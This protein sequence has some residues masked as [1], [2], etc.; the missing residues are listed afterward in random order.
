MVSDTRQKKWTKLNMDLKNPI[1]QDYFSKDYIKHKKLLDKY[2]EGAETFFYYWLKYGG[3]ENTIIT[4]MKTLK[5]SHKNFIEDVL[6]CQLGIE[7]RHATRNLE[8]F[9]I[10]KSE[11]N[12]M[13]ELGRAASAIALQGFDT[14]DKVKNKMVNEG[15]NYKQVS[16]A[17]QEVRETL[18][19]I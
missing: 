11:I 3:A 1:K 13:S 17:I 14:M 8:R 9:L 7:N 19:G 4:T 18:K 12:G 6:P 2:E 16:W 10:F 5:Y 15:F